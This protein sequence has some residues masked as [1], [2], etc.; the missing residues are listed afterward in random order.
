MP[1][2]NIRPFMRA[3][4]GL[5]PY[6]IVID[7]GGKA[8]TL[9]MYGEV[10]ESRPI[11]WWTGKPID[12]NFIILS[13]FLNDLTELEGKDNITVH[14]NS[15][16]GSFYAGLAIYNRL[17][18]LK[19]SVT[20]INDSLAASAGSIIFMA[21][22][23]GKRKC[24]AGSNLMV[25]GVLT[26]LIGYYNIPDLRGV[27]KEL[28]SHNKAAIA[29]YMEA[30]GLDAETIKAAM[31]KDTFMTGQEAVEAGWAD[32]VISGEAEPVM[33]LSPDRTQL[34]VGGRAVAACLFGKLPDSIPQMTEAE[35]SALSEPVTE[36]AMQDGNIISNGGIENMEI[37]NAED[38]RNAFPEIVR[39]IE[40]AAHTEGMTDERN[41]I[42]GIESIEAAVGNPE[43]VRNA[44]YGPNPMN[45]QELSFAA[46]QAHAKAGVSMMANL[47]ADTNASGVEDVT[48]SAAPVNDPEPNDHK[49]VEAQA[50]ADVAKFLNTKKE[51]F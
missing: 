16:G 20:T 46:M 13:E 14:I 28:E 34:M 5:K 41:R 18:S 39:E 1:N 49:S 30:T 22:D 9:N 8:A 2:P 44:K 51:V 11:D 29:A 21:G 3:S 19:A 40:N 38:L 42:Q 35:F 17:R 26:P 33:K 48:A 32:E 27:I 6:N 12:G 25:H 23:K 43:M 37:K 4:S 7:E 50:A 36:P 31:S 15:V 45:A 10:V 47:E 24:Y